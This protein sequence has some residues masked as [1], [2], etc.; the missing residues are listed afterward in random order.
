M[1]KLR[2]LLLL[3]FVYLTFCSCSL[4]LSLAHTH[5]HPPPQT[6]T[7]THTYTLTHSHKV[8]H[9]HKYPPPTLSFNCFAVLMKIPRRLHFLKTKQKE[10]KTFRKKIKWNF[11]VQHN[12]SISKELWSLLL[13]TFKL[14]FCPF[15]L[16]LKNNR[17]LHI[18]DINGEIWELF[19]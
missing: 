14:I 3:V 17:L 7:P 13:I 1:S 9:T 4:S 15:G 19:P 11:F 12:N 16:F 2:F 10:E 8:T 6:Y 5:T 18:F